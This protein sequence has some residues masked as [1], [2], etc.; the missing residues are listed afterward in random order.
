MLLAL[1]LSAPFVHPA[2][3]G[4][5]VGVVQEYKQDDDFY[6]LTESGSS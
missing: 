3:Q 4:E 2:A 5:P 1:L 6:W